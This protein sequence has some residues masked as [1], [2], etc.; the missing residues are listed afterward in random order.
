MT[1][2]GGDRKADAG[3]GEPLEGFT[4]EVEV[5]AEQVQNTELVPEVAS[6]SPKYAVCVSPL[7][8]STPGW[9]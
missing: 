1:V 3:L 6:R 8:Q 5:R 2:S 4:S 9:H 7:Q